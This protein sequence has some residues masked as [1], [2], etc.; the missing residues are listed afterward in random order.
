MVDGM[1]VLWA[2]FDTPSPVWPDAEVRRWLTNV[3]ELLVQHGLVVEAGRLDHI[4]CPDCP[5]GHVEEV[6]E[7][8]GADGRLRCYIPCPLSLRVEIPP[9]TLRRWTLDVEKT[10][11]AVASAMSIQARPSAIIPGRLWRL[12]KTQ[13]QGV[14]REV[15]LARGLAWEDGQIVAR[16]VGTGG[17]P[18][19]LVADQ[20]PPT[21]LWPGRVPAVVLLSRVASLG[22][23]GVEADVTHMMMLVKDA[24]ATAERA[25]LLPITP[26]DRTKVINQHVRA[27]M[28]KQLDQDA[29]VAAYKLHGTAREAA[30][31]LEKEGIKVH[32]STIARA[33]ERAKKAEEIARTTDSQS[34]RR[35]VAS[36]RRDSGR[37]IIQ[38]TQHPN[39]E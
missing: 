21:D 9:A 23:T 36:H 32:F 20:V 13:W 17:R 7:R 19:V 14:S 34:V 31:A 25:S 2:C 30:A 12:G 8:L 11:A 22:A 29:Y 4:A 37:K 15:L 10:V 33:V 16:R 18:I 35:T 6:F 39:S 38:R 3:R 5:D 27:A 28:K 24:D 26:K 1:Q